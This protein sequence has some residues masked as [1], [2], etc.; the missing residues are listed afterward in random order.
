MEINPDRRTISAAELAST[1]RRMIVVDQGRHM[2]V[3]LLARARRLLVQPQDRSTP[4]VTLTAPP[5]PDSLAGLEGQ[6]E[7]EPSL[8]DTPAAVNSL[9][10]R[11]TRA[12]IGAVAILG[13][14]AAGVA[15]TLALVEL[16]SGAAA[17]ASASV[18][19]APSAAPRPVAR[20]VETTKV[21]AA[22]PPTTTGTIE[23]APTWG[24]L[25]VFFDGRV[26]G[27]T[28]QA[29]RAFEVP[30]GWHAVQIGSSGLAQEIIV[31]CG[32]VTRVDR[33]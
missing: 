29:V 30:C 12:W 4:T 25:R 6:R 5:A 22:E 15:S 23:V 9:P 27:E 13:L 8:T 26:V 10:P 31:P 33:R 21:R 2:L 18:A 17:H 19:R 14:A 28:A 16:K 11:S 24:N 1:L 3:R 20:L 7:K 32:G